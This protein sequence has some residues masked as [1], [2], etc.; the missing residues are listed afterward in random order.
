LRAADKPDFCTQ[1]LN[2]AKFA[3][4]SK[5]WWVW[6]N[7]PSPFSYFSQKRSDPQ[8][9]VGQKEERAKKEGQLAKGGV[10]HKKE[11]PSKGSSNKTV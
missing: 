8:R 9:G 3:R 6:K 10:I 2:L 1:L 7:L 11:E 4:F 5:G